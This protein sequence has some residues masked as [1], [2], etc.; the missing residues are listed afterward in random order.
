MNT[1][2][3]SITTSGPNAAFSLRNLLST[4]VRIRSELERVLPQAPADSAI[5]SAVPRFRLHTFL[6]LPISTKPGVA[7][8]RPTSAP[9]QQLHH[10]GH[11][12][13]PAGMLPAY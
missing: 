11:D 3:I 9:I 8:Q 7:Q 5:R 2:S 4:D 13:H 6:G 12:S 1:P 10:S